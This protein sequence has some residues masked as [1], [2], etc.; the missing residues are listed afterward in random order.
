MV[1]PG[2]FL[3]HAAAWTGRPPIPMAAVFDGWSP[4]SGVIPPELEAPIEVLKADA[5]AR[6]LLDGDASAEE[7]M[8]ELRSRVPAVD[9]YMRTAGYRLAAGFDLTNPTI[10]ERP[11][12]RARPAAFGSRP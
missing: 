6:A 3:L 2:D 4:V 7:R 12:C 9:E 1:P 5:D 10:G 11:D 8:A